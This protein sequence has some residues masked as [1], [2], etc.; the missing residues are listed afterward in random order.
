LLGVYRGPLLGEEADTDQ[1]ARRPRERLASKFLRAAELLGRA[2]EDQGM[3]DGAAEL[4]QRMFDAHP[5]VEAGGAGLMRCALAAGRTAD[6]RRIFDEYRSRS[7]IHGSSEPGPE[8]AKLYAKLSPGPAPGLW[9][10]FGTA[11]PARASRSSAPTRS[12]KNRPS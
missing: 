4:Y 1:W 6:A 12:P 2:L 10:P 8:I 9:A 11:R 3:F 7:S 5:L